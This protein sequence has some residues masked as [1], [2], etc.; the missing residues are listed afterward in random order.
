MAKNR[1]F[2]LLLLCLSLATALQATA[3]EEFK[4]K[5][6]KVESKEAALQL[7]REYLPKLS[8]AEDLRDLQNLWQQADAQACNAYFTEAAK[9]EPNNPVYTYL[10]LRFE[11]DEAVQF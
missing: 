2:W 4:A 6:A 9:K 8:T 11:Q 10:N 1:L 7:I 3:I 5:T